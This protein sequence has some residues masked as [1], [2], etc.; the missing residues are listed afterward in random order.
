MA[1]ETTDSSNKER[2]VLCIRWVD[3]DINTHEDFVGM[4]NVD[5]TDVETIIT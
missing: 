2:C 1:D 3:Q 4:V 5:T